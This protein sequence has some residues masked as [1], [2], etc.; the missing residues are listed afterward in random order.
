MN[1]PKNSTKDGASEQSVGWWTKTLK[2]L[3][4]KQEQTKWELY[5]ENEHGKFWTH[6]DT[7][8]AV[9][10]QD[11]KS[12]VVCGKYVLEYYKTAEDAKKEIE[13]CG[14]RHLAVEA[15]T[16]AIKLIDEGEQNNGVIQLNN[17]QKTAK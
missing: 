14:L 2:K 7:P 9:H 8:L 11:E 13:M 5:I 16:S 3:F 4:G 17:N 10:E 15:I 6:P 1:T 12:A